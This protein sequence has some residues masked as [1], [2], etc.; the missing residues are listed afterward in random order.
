MDRV[1][2]IASIIVFGSVHTRK[3]RG[4]PAHAE[5]NIKLCVCQTLVAA[6]ERIAERLSVFPDRTQVLRHRFKVCVLFQVPQPLMQIA[7]P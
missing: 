2:V 4:V 6:T 1:V 7:K 3:Q 5:V